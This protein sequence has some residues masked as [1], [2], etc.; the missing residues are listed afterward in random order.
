MNGKKFITA[1]IV[2]FV[3]MFILGYLW[4][5][6]IMGDFYSANSYVPER[7]APRMELIILGVLSLALLMAYVYP[8]GYSGGSPVTEGLK[9]GLII[10]VLWVTPHS[11]IEHGAAVMMTGKMVLVDG[12]WHL[13][14]QGVAGILIG[15]VYGTNSEAA[16]EG[17]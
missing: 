10:G 14:E 5:M 2:G 4:H 3:A 1:W 16:A 6:V 13:V 7:E 9:F 8:K 12:I 11:L 17:A 15:L